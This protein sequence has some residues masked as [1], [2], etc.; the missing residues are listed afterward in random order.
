MSANQMISNKP[1]NKLELRPIELGIVVFDDKYSDDLY[2]SLAKHYQINGDINFYFPF[3]EY[4]S[5]EDEFSGYDNCFNN[6]NRLT[7]V[8]DELHIFDENN[9]KFT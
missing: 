3:I 8:L 2:D 7:E 4:F 6:R 5:E 9:T 1:I